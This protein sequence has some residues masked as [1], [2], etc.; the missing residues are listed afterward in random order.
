MALHVVVLR[1]CPVCSL[2]LSVAWDGGPLE[3]LAPDGTKA[4]T[5]PKPGPH[6]G[7]DTASHILAPHF[8]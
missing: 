8:Y 4:R 2:L 7:V 6:L 5:R 1:L 3:G